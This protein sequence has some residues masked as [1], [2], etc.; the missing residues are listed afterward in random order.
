VFKEC[1]KKTFFSEPQTF[2]AEFANGYF[3]GEILHK[4]GLQDDFEQFSQNKY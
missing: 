2:A 4:N 3:I 1:L